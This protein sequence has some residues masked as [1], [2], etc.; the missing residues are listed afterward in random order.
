MRIEVYLFFF[1]EVSINICLLQFLYIIKFGDGES[2]TY[3]EVSLEAVALE[4][5]LQC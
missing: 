5:L 2:W 1:V 3:K 4:A